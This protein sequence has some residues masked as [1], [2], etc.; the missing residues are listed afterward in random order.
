MTL[1][2]KFMV[3]ILIPVAGVLGLVGVGAWTLR[4]TS[5]GLDD[6]VNRQ[7][8][9]LI[10]GEITPLIAE[11]ILP[12]IDEDLVRLQELDRS[13]QLMLEADRDMHQA[14]IAER[15]ALTA[16][17]DVFAAA[18][19]TNAEN[20]GQADTRT[21]KAS[22]QFSTDATRKL[23]TRF[24]AEFARWR[25]ASRAVIEHGESE[26][27]Y[28]AALASSNGGAAQSAFDSARDLLD[29]LQELQHQQI[30]A[31]L[32]RIDEKK[33][34]IS[35]KRAAMDERKETVLAVGRDITNRS[36]TA[37]MIFVII[38]AAVVVI[39]PLIGFF[40]ARSL[41]R[42]LKRMVEGLSE[43][44]KQVNEAATQVS[45]SSQQIAQGA[46]EQA[47]SLEQTSASLEE[48]AAMTRTNAANAEQA[49]KLAAQARGNAESGDRTMGEL[50][51]AMAAINESSGQIGKII[52]VI[53]EIAFQTNLLAL[54]AAVEAA[55]AGEHGK[56]FAVV[57]EEVRNL[58]LRAA[59]A[60][61]E[62]TTL[63]EDSVSRTQTGTTVANAAADS[64]RSIVGDVTS[65]AELLHGIAKASGEQ[66]QGV[67]QINTA[68][69]Q[70]DRV[71][72]QNA[73][74]AE[75]SASASEHLSAQ[76]V[77]LD[78]IVSELSAIVGR[79]QAHRPVTREAARTTKE[80]RPRATARTVTGAQVAGQ[81]HGD[82]EGLSN[83]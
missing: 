30:E 77:A 18:D 47:S 40:I 76:S 8:V 24:V 68:V 63:I 39:I 21:Q 73:A 51:Q 6:V 37:T 48:M 33:A 42:A 1:N 35:A 57:A 12:V 5:R 3:M 32:A 80:P 20:I 31:T 70:L 79:S 78:S 25:S 14:L 53:E 22:A 67:D 2:Q 45:G 49:N 52:K 16:E 81:D 29:Q 50:N 66:A 11:Q 71:T 41:A 61:R 72:Q 26:A 38:G 43:G 60:A 75:E 34:Q 83:F 15:V 46:S 4:D 23:Y 55:R 56:G 44:S 13:L 59:Q 65:V 58:A 9:G 36:N 17:G 27:D 62:T 64:L 82:S 7:F 54:N 28:A 19:A 10:E 74:G 69:S